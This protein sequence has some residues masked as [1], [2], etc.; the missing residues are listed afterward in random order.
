MR[1][2]DSYS[3]VVRGERAY[4][5][6]FERSFL[7][8]TPLY[9]CNHSVIERG[10]SKKECSDRIS[11]VSSGHSHDECHTRT[12]TVIST[13]KLCQNR[14][15]T[16]TEGGRARGE[17]PADQCGNP[18][19]HPRQL[20]QHQRWE[21]RRVCATCPHTAREYPDNTVSYPRRRCQP[22]LCVV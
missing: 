20:L 7:L 9:S 11:S 8:N 1:R 13:R 18:H 4:C 5:H 22:V 19:R 17:C 14:G 6:V 2:R 3:A 15:A 21:E 12:G 10:V 16:L